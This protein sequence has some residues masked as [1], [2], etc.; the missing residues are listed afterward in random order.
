MN[1]YFY[2]ECFYS[3]CPLYNIKRLGIKIIKLIYE[4]LI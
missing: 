4:I 1:D 2:D 3:N